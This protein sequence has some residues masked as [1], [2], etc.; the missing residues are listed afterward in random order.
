MDDLRDRVG[1]SARPHVVD[2]PYRIAVCEPC[3]RVDDLLG[4]ALHFRVVPLDGRKVEF[5][6]MKFVVVP[7]RVV[8]GEARLLG[9]KIVVGDFGRAD[10]GGGRIVPEARR[11]R[12]NSGRTSGGS[13]SAPEADE[14]C[15]AA[16]HSDQ[17]AGPQG[18]LR[19]MALPD[20]AHAPRDHDRLVVAVPVAAARSSR[21]LE[22]AE[23]AAQRGPSEF[24]VEARRANRRVE[25]DLERGREVGRRAGSVLFPGLFETR[26]A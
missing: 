16:Q 19:D 3:A 21:L 9:M 5:L 4:A 18:V 20:P 11:V 14:H 7:G 17:H 13:G 22:G 8:L 24:V 26:N 6:T 2:G 25:H 12:V 23:V 15:G 1:E 10:A